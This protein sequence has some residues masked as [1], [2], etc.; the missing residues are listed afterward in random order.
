MTLL[1][2]MISRIIL[3]VKQVKPVTCFCLPVSTSP[4][5]GCS[6]YAFWR[7]MTEVEQN[8]IEMLPPNPPAPLIVCTCSQ[9]LS[10]Q[11][12]KAR[13]ICGMEYLS[14][15]LPIWKAACT[16]VRLAGH[17]FQLEQYKTCRTFL[18]ITV[19]YKVLSALDLHLR[20]SLH[21]LRLMSDWGWL[22]A[23]SHFNK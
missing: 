12:T 5:L 7:L 17:A 9:S 16:L 8:Q 18:P 15:A 22:S 21:W 2:V 4:W 20:T 23:S 3:L 6:N 14:F 13:N 10:T 19:N 11:L 1:C